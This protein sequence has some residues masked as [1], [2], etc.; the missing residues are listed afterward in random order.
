VYHRRCHT[1]V[2]IPD[3]V[4]E[5]RRVRFLYVSRNLES[6][7]NPCFRDSHICYVSF[8]LNSH[9]RILPRDCFVFAAGLVGFSIATRGIP[10]RIADTPEEECSETDVTLYPKTI[11]KTFRVWCRQSARHVKSERIGHLVRVW[12]GELLAELS[13]VWSFRH[14]VSLIVTQ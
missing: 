11:S 9:I 5:A 7:G 3:R 14:S 12:M 1:V 13:I 10:A 6:L 8:E 4:L 2:E